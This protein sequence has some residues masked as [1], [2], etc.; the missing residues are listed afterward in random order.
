MV[1]AA[2]TAVSTGAVEVIVKVNVVTPSVSDWLTSPIDSDY[3]LFG[4]TCGEL[5]TPEESP[6]SCVAGE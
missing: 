4:G 1:T 3:E 5:F 6:Y 2:E